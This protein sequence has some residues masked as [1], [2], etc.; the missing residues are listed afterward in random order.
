MKKETC[1]S[2]SRAPNLKTNKN[3]ELHNYEPK[4]YFIKKW[5]LYILFILNA[6]VCIKALDGS[7][8]K[9]KRPKSKAATL[10]YHQDA[11]SDFCEEKKKPCLK[12]GFSSIYLEYYFTPSQI[13][14]HFL[15]CWWTGISLSDCIKCFE[16]MGFLLRRKMIQGKAIIIPPYFFS[17]FFV[18]K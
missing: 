4:S 18:S 8:K 10:I 7:W 16:I 2:F 5:N 1:T 14:S 15:I 17:L 9:K 3:Y 12:L 11:A 13:Y 6:G